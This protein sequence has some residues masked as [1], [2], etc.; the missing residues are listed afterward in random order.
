MFENATFVG[1]LIFTPDKIG[2]MKASFG[3]LLEIH[4]SCGVCFHFFRK[5]GVCLIS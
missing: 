2:R 5:I 3:H 1:F 4:G